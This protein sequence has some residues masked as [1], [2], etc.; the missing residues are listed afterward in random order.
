MDFTLGDGDIDASFPLAANGSYSGV[1]PAGSYNA[2]VHSSIVYSIYTVQSQTLGLYNLGTPTISGN[3]TL[4]T[5]SIPALARLSGTVIGATIPATGIGISAV[6]P[7]SVVSSSSPDI[8]TAQYQALLPRN[9]SYSV[10]VGMVLIE[11]ESLQGAITFPLTPAALNL[12]NDTS[13]YDF[14]APSLPSRV[15]IAGKVTDSSNNPVNGVTVSLYCE[16]L[17]NTPNVRFVHSVR[18][19]ASGNYSVSVLSGTNYTMVFIPPLSE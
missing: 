2:G 19:D 10:N 13:G 12:A 14:T 6:D 8:L 9:A 11:G 18:T 5:Y 17:T 16:S 4:P 15:T 7:N 3:T 1:L